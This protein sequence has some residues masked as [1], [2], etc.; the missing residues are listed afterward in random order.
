QLGLIDPDILTNDNAAL[1][2]KMTGNTAILTSRSP[3]S[4]IGVWTK[5]MQ[6]TDPSVELIAAPFPVLNEG[7]TRYIAGANY[8]FQ[9]AFSAAITTS[10][11]DVDAALKLLDYAYSPEGD[12]LFNFGV[13]GVSFEYDAQG[14]PQFNAFI[15]DNPNGLTLKEAMILYCRNSS[16]GPFVKSAGPILSQRTYKNQYDAPLLWYKS[17][18]W[19]RNLPRMVYSGE[20][21]VELNDVMNEINTIT[22]EMTVKIIIGDKSLDYC[23]EYVREIEAAGIADAL[24]IVQTAYDR[25]MGK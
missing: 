11:K 22:E 13:E 21:S 5:A 10:C 4:G 14:K 25:Q 19:S 17:V 18:D 15:K 1:D 23:D 3:D 12:M 7:D 8:R 16:G 2:G 9:G 20:E 6:A 24:K